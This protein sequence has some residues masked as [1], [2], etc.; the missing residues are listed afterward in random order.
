VTDTAMRANLLETF[1][2]FTELV[3]KGVGEELAVFAILAVLLTIEEVIRN[4]VL[5]G[6]LHDGDDAFHVSSVHFT[7]A[8]AHIN[9]SLATDDP[10]ITTT[11]TLDGSHGELNLLL[12]IN[13]GVEDTQNVLEGRLFR[14]VQRLIKRRRVKKEKEKM[15][16]EWE[17][18]NRQTER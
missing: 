2:V 10:S 16:K 1:H 11:T 4:L 17:Y 14:D 6:V 7:S 9:F 3:I 15:I 12:S 5:T 18:Q 8:F 13:V